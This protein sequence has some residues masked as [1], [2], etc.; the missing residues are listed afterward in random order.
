MKIK[1]LFSAGKMNKDIDERLIKNGEFIDAYNIRVLNTAGSDVGAVENE[2]GN[3]KVTNLS[4]T[5]EPV[6][7]GSIADESDEK[8]Y[9]FITNNLGHSY[10][11]E[12]DK[13]SSITTVVLKDERV[14]DSQVLNFSKNYKITGVNI[15]YNSPKKEKILLFTDGLNQ[16]RMISINRAKGYGADNFFED[17]ISLYKKPPRQSPTVLPY[18]TGIINENSI[19]DSFFAFGYRY[20]Y[21]DGC[22]SAISSFSEFQF[23]PGAF[24]VDWTSMENNGMLGIFN[25]YKITHDTGDHRVTDIQLVFKY[26]VE[27]AVYVIDTINKKESSLLDNSTNTYEFVNK[28][29]SKQL[30]KDEIYRIFDDVPLTAKAQDIIK[31]RIVFGNTT[32]QYDLKRNEIDDDDIRINYD[33][34]L[35][36]QGQE[37]DNVS[38]TLSVSDTKFDIDFSTVE[39]KKGHSFLFTIDLSSASAGTPPN[40]Y[41]SGSATVTG[42]IVLTESYSSLYNF[43]ISVDFVGFLE[44]ISSIFASIV[45]TDS[46]NNAIIDDFGSFIVDDVTATNI[47]LI[48]PTIVHRVD[49]TPLNT[50][51]SDFTFINENFFIS[52]LKISYRESISVSSLK[53][54]RSYEVGLVYLDTYGRYTSVL[55]PK[56]SLGESSSDIF[57]PIK[58]SVDVNSIE[59]TINHLPPYWADRY[60]FFVKTNKDFHYNIYGT[61]FYD[62]GQYRWVLLQGANLGK[63]EAGD[64]LLVK[65]DSGGALDTEV[66]CKVLEVATKSGPDV[67]NANEGWIEGNVDAQGQP[68]IEL[69]GTYMKI[70]PNGFQMDFDPNNFLTYS[71][72]R[73]FGKGFLNTS[74]GVNQLIVPNAPKPGIL[75]VG[76]YYSPPFVDKKLTPGTRISL[77]I[78]YSESDEEPNFSFKKEYVVND[79]YETDTHVASTQ[80]IRHAFDKWLDSET[81]FTK[82]SQTDSGQQV[83]VY[84]IPAQDNDTNFFSVYMYNG[85]FTGT[86]S[87]WKLII[88]PS[89]S[90][91]LFEN[92]T[93]SGDIDIILQDG[94]VVFE[95]DPQDINEDTYWEVSDTFDITGGYHK[96]NTQSQSA[97]SESAKCKLSFGNC[98]SFGNGV[99]S[100]QVLDDRF[101][102]RLDIR[103]RPNVYLLNGYTSREDNAKL[104]YSGSSNENTGYNSLNEFNSSRGIT[105]FMDIKFGSIQKVFSRDSDLII[106]QEDRVSKVLFGKTIISSPDGSGSLSQIESVLGQDVPFSSEYGIGLNP[107]SFANYEGRIYFTDAN[108]GAVLRLSS[109][110]VTPI[111]YQ[112]MKA[113]FKKNLYENRNRVNIG[114]FDPKFHQYALTI[115]AYDL[116]LQ[117]V[118]LDCDS[119]F[120]ISISESFSYKLIVGDITGTATLSYTV[121]NPVNITVV[122]DG[123]TSVYPA[124]TGT[125]VINIAV[126]SADNLADITIAPTGGAV[127]V[128][129][130]VDHGCPIPQSMDVVLVVVNSPEVA[131]K[132]IINRYSHSGANVYNSDLDVFDFDGLTRYE[133]LT[134]F[135]GSDFIPDEGDTVT[136]SSFRDFSTHT[137]TFIQYNRL[138]HLV[139]SQLL[140]VEN[141]L[142]Q[143]TYQT[144]V[145]TTTAV[146]EEK[147]TTFVFNR[148]NTSEKLYLIWDYRYNAPAL[149]TGLPLCYSTTSPVDACCGC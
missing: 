5:D 140:T 72:R 46:P 54:N 101:K 144:I 48:C 60:K 6:C 148:S 32:S 91:A 16:P 80:G 37:G 44:T 104:I 57:V 41:F 2:K 129:L 118:T 81:N 67:V 105:K 8:I 120:N 1:N 119:E 113:F 20:K 73:V 17:D 13:I 27:N 139:S 115:G 43:S 22:Y 109:D 15:V 31:D 33:T 10:I 68:L 59:V 143:A 123:V 92:S 83:N 42:G 100:I 11:Y 121:N 106:F 88:N 98:Y 97:S 138:G 7:I 89:E 18:N 65:S 23:N 122:Y 55:L 84:R 141:I 146:S 147:T 26:P 137:G 107:E 64:T 127:P 112:G 117:D 77:S 24:S 134:G 29:I 125:G 35:V 58:N 30:P 82:T 47:K 99:E 40:D 52:D 130:S 50:S 25:G 74:A 142:D 53:S 96:G 66:K 126:T 128:L 34:K 86:S 133:V 108:R 39:L 116:P 38:Y 114:G 94:L 131:G 93:I 78:V 111:S 62:E 75:Q 63:V 69:S 136:I 71:E 124:L 149:P 135:M 103:S 9:W 70:R 3:T 4:L 110:G 14:L 85:L 21:L 102:H 19:K 49:N 51:D 145:N 132:T 36:S 76:D 79:T 45:E 87:H 12:Y 90:T 28:K 95:T 56:E 61:I